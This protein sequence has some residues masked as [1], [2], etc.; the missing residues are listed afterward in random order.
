MPCIRVIS[1]LT[2]ACSLLLTLVIAAPATTLAADATVTGA[3]CTVDDLRA[4]INT[5][6][7]GGT[8]VFDCDDPVISFALGDVVMIPANAE[9]TIDGSNNGGPQI[10]LD[11]NDETR[12][13]EI[14]AGGTL[15]LHHLTL[16]NAIVDMATRGGAILNSG[17]LTISQST[18]TANSAGT[19]GNAISNQGIAT[20][21]QSSFISN[22]TLT[23]SSS[24]GGAIYNDL[25]G[26]L[27]IKQSRFESN[28][29]IYGGALYNH[30]A[31]TVSQSSFIN[32]RAYIHGGAIDTDGPATTITTSTFS[33]NTGGPNPG[34]TLY[35]HEAQ[36]PREKITSLTWSTI[37]QPESASITI[38]IREPIS[39]DGVILSGPGPHCEITEDGEIHDSYSLAT[40]SSCGLD[41]T[42]SE[43]KVVAPGLGGITS[44]TI[45]GVE[46]SYFPLVEGSMAIDAGPAT[47]DTD[48]I[49]GPEADQLG[50]PRPFN[51]L[52]DI[53]AVEFT[54]ESTLLC[55]NAWN[56]ALR[57]SDE[58][59][60]SETMI[61]LPEDGP[62]TL[63]VN[64]WNGATRVAT[65]C[66]RTEQA[67][68][69]TGE[70]TISAC[71]NTWN[72]T[73]RVSPSCTRSEHQA[74]I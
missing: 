42:G 33:G 71:I 37:V 47:C 70:D 56:G 24:Q 35:F 30:G 60:R 52:C 27:T 46:Q 12:L 32:N 15:A 8:V 4:A 68:I 22:T 48:A 64:P 3:T 7:D 14:E 62:I 23:T 31:M 61:T 69:A 20:V 55:A 26:T 38:S 9:V 1:T 16:Q 28:T 63:C 34:S 49:E 45:N 59:T 51:H 50:T 18:F 66:S 73:L 11:G 58:C 67:I 65:S 41:G 25:E 6:S 2:L 43:E 36:I 74:W 40:D 17:T 57:L 72:H 21:I 39:L 44:S 5:A 10:I 54:F 19:G 53:G 13:F 29:A